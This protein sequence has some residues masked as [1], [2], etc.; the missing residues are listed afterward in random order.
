MNQELRISEMS[1]VSFFFLNRSSISGL[2]WFETLITVLF[3]AQ[4]IELLKSRGEVTRTAES[5]FVGDVGQAQLPLGNQC[6]PL[7]QFDPPDEI[8]G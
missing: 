6:L 7:F 8:T 5:D 3:R 4:S 2:G 1:A